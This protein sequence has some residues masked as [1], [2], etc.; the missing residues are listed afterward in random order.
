MLS[1]RSSAHSNERP[2]GVAS[3]AA[4]FALLAVAALGFVLLLLTGKASLSAG[5]ILLGGGLEQLGPVVFVMEGAIAAVLAFGL[6]KGWRWTRLA[7]ILFAAGGVLLDVPAISSAVVDTRLLA[8]ARGGAETVVRVV[9]IYYL[10]QEP[11]KDW[12]ASGGEQNSGVTDQVFAGRKIAWRYFDGV[13]IA[14]RSLALLLPC[15]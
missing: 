7:S 13:V 9:V 12:F 14:R 11:V 2:A 15:S 8:L 6:W 4:V 1:L 10:S 5:A 3:I